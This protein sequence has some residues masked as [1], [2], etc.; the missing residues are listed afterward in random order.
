MNHELRAVEV[1][2]LAQDFLQVL[3]KMSAEGLMG[4]EGPLPS[5]VMW[6][7][8]GGLSSSFCAAL[9]RIDK[10]PRTWQL[11]FPSVR[12]E[13]DQDGHHGAFHNLT[14]EVKSHHFCHC[15]LATRTPPPEQCGG[16]P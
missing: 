6:L 14:S 12:D 16:T 9:Y 15:F 5:S 4:R 13:R 10:H 2:I 1:V 8:A 3:V 11:A 7:L